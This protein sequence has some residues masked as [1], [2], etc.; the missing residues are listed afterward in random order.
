MG[1]TQYTSVY[2]P[3]N[4]KAQLVKIAELEGYSI[5][6]GRQ[7]QLAKFIESLLH[8]RTLLTSENSTVSPFFSLQPELRASIFKLGELSA[9]Q[10]KRI[11]SILSVLLEM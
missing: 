9:I 3:I 6:Q 4:L 8:E 1:K 11:G 5:K 10:Q 7:S 2:L